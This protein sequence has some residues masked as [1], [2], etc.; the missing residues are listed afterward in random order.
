[1]L[2]AVEAAAVTDEVSFTAV[3]AN[4]AKPPLPKPIAWPR[5]GKM[6]AASTLNR[7]MTEIDCATCSSDASMTGAVAAIALPP[8]IDEPT[9]MRQATLELSFSAFIMRYA[10]MSEI[11]MVQTMTGRLFAPTLAMVLM[12]SEKPRMMTAHWR[13][14]LDVNLTPVLAVSLAASFGTH[15]VMI[16]PSK[17]E[18]TG[19]PTIS[20]E[21]EPSF[22][23]HSTVATAATAA[24]SAM[25]G[26]FFFID[27]ILF[28]Q[29]FRSNNK[30]SSRREPSRFCLSV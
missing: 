19:A 11:E 5:Y 14:F 16:M 24:H 12:L 23:P 2:S 29:S 25:P 4:T 21:N 13:I 26:A 20:S 15:S 8:Q 1:M 7:K 22:T 30:T 27:C 18:N 6:S 28:A 3:P 17:I 10:T 9:P